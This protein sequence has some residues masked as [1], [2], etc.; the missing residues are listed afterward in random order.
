MLRIGHT[1]R[2]FMPVA[3]G[4]FKCVSLVALTTTNAAYLLPASVIH[5]IIVKSSPE[6]SLFQV[7]ESI[8]TLLVG[9]QNKNP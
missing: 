6:W 7:S 5:E 8:S 3:M 9:V 2:P 1:V 4:G